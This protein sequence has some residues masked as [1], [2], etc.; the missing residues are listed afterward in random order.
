MF[1]EDGWLRTGDLGEAQEDG[2]LRITGRRREVIVTANGKAIAPQPIAEAICAH[3]LIAQV[4]I[5][6]ER[7]NY[8]TALVA[9]DSETLEEIRAEQGLQLDNEELARHAAVYDVVERWIL[10]V[11]EA[12]PAHE[13]IRKFAILA[14]GLSEEEG[15]LTPTDGVRRRAVTKRHQALLDS[16]YEERY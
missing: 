9:L 15:D 11:N 14:G 12:L 10:G 4:L 8:L 5:H 16:F 6:G 7:R 13:T 3:S 2:R 1:T